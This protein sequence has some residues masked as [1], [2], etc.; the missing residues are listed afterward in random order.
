MKKAPKL[1]HK[2][3]RVCTSKTVIDPKGV[4]SGLAR[5]DVI[6]DAGG[7]IGSKSIMFHQNDLGA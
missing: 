3:L 4:S 2:F 1:V 5:H 7:Q 6:G